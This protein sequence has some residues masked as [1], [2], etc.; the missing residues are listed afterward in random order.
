MNFDWDRWEQTEDHSVHCPEQALVFAINKALDV[1]RAEETFVALWRYWQKTFPSACILVT[2]TKNHFNG[3]N[4]QLRFWF[5]EPNSFGYGQHVD[6]SGHHL[7]ATVVGAPNELRMLVQKI[8]PM[9]LFEEG[10]VE[11]PEDAHLR[12]TAPSSTIVWRRK[13]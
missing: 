3:D 7:I 12:H 6:S 8:L 11:P 4:Q 10:V 13:I 1:S 9:D 2:M 5:G